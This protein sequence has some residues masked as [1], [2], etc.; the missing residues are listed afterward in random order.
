MVQSQLIHQNVPMA[1]ESLWTCGQGS[2][3]TV[4][5]RGTGSLL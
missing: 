3:K 4:G 2:R 5:A 1:E